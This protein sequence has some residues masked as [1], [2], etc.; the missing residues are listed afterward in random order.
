[1]SAAPIQPKLAVILSTV[2]FAAIFVALVFI[3]KPGIGT[4]HFFYLPIALVAIALGPRYGVA[5]GLL[6]ATLYTVAFVLNDRLPTADV[7]TFSTP[8]RTL[9]YT[10]CG[11]LV[12]WFASRNR[13]LIAQLEVLAGRDR[14]TG[15]P[16]ARAFEAA[17]DRRFALGEPFALLLGDLDNLR[18]RNEDVGYG[19]GDLVLVR[20][21]ETLGRLLKP[22]EEI[23]RVGGDEFAILATVRSK[24]DAAARANLLE[25]W[26]AQD[27][28]DVTFG[29]AAYPAEGANALGLVRVADE[30][31]YAR[32]LV[33]GRRAVPPQ[34]PKAVG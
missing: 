18:R 13:E 12:G 27:G 5:A 14:L 24:E 17:V 9:T 26:L 19:E 32:K 34:L 16:N 22:G 3:E 29:W 30:R 10:L 8:I 4:G 23:A 7:L 25:R 6:A 33:S 20:L 28:L 21:A 31:L 11:A 15:L 1:V 2:A